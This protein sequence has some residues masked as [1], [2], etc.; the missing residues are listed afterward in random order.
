MLRFIF[1]ILLFS[2]V[3]PIEG[4]VFLRIDRELVS[5]GEFK[6]VIAEF[7][8][9]YSN[10]LK[11]V[12]FSKRVNSIS[13]DLD[14]GFY[15]I[16]VQEERRP[17]KCIFYKIDTLIISL[18]KA[19]KINAKF[20]SRINEELK[21]L[22]FFTEYIRGLKFYQKQYLNSTLTS[23]KKVEKYIVNEFQNNLISHSNWFNKYSSMDFRFNEYYQLA[24]SINSL[25]YIKEN[26][27]STLL[28][29]LPKIV[30]CNYATKSD[31][32]EQLYFIVLSHFSD[33][34]IINKRT[35]FQK[36]DY[37]FRYLTEKTSSYYDI[38]R[39][40][41]SIHLKELTK[42]KLPLEVYKL[43]NSNNFKK[44]DSID[45]IRIG[46][47]TQINTMVGTNSKLGVRENINDFKP[48]FFVC[49]L[50]SPSCDHCKTSTSVLNEN[51]DFLKLKGFKF[52]SIT[53]E[54]LD[55]SQIKMINWATNIEV[56]DGLNNLLFSQLKINYTPA[57][58]ILD[59][60]RRVVVMAETETQLL[61]YIWD[62]K[63]GL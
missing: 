8:R 43:I 17:L 33:N 3:L 47:G 12:I 25:L 22:D 49:Y 19:H 9:G 29:I 41:I 52:L 63:S 61:N 35:T 21:E 40:L 28:S 1:A 34:E 5:K 48:K 51:V 46:A 53:T 30:S 42:A 15:Y 39:I 16:F 44:V 60:E 38:N 11:Q 56:L 6:I 55:S 10:F 50:W 2:I 24:W 7:E 57:F 27:D 62:L 45:L 37:S 36:I 4:R 23:S 18:D 59:S 13:L 20:S 32:I 14:S 31:I 58:F 54:K 26:F